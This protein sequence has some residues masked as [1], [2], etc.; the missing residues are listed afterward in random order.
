MKEL[1]PFHHIL[2]WYEGASSV[3][4]WQGSPSD[5]FA[6]L[7]TK[8]RDKLISAI[9]YFVRETKHCHT[10]KLFKLLNFLDFEHF[11]QTGRTVTGLRYSAWPMGPVPDQLWREIN[12]GGDADLRAAI[13]IIEDDGEPSRLAAFRTVDDEDWKAERRQFKKRVLK[14]KRAFD[15]TIFTKREL[16]IMG[17]LSEFFKEFRADDMKEFSHL[18][19]LPWRQVFKGGEGKGSR[20]H[21]NSRSNPT[22]SCTRCRRLMRMSV[23]IENYCSLGSNVGT[24][25]ESRVCFPLGAVRVR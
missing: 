3:T 25:T 8:E 12:Q 11:R 24:R 6:M 23:G 9:I 4:D 22:R 18:K 10:L 15:K 19:H 13:V 2:F 7:V 21:Q 20:S 17:R 1:W 16:M 14:P 5:T